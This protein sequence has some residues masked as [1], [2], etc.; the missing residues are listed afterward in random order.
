MVQSPSRLNQPKARTFRH[1]D[2]ECDQE[3]V[4]HSKFVEHAD[5]GQGGWCHDAQLNKQQ[6]LRFAVGAVI[7]KMMTTTAK[8]TSVCQRLAMPD[9]SEISF[10]PKSGSRPARI[11]GANHDRGNRISNSAFAAIS[12]VITLETSAAVCSIQPKKTAQS[13]RLIITYSRGAS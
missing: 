7:A 11:S 12:N 8:N 2:V 13:L 1:G 10:R 4:C 6:P 5:Q 3:D 9:H